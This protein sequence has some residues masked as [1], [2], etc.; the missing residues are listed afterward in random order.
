MEEQIR[1]LMDLTF[2]DTGTAVVEI[3]NCP[4]QAESVPANLDRFDELD[5]EVFSKQRW[6]LLVRSHTE[7][8]RVIWPDGHE[9]RGI[10]KH[11]EDLKAMFVALPD[12]RIDQHPVK[13][14]SG[15][16][17][18]VIGVMEGTFSKP[19][20]IP[21]GGVI[22][23]N[24]NRVS[25]RMATIAHWRNGRIYEEYLFWDNDAYMKQLGLSK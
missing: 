12:L 2:P 7:D 11:I 3:E 24:G 14:G 1:G 13:F 4:E 20:W 17:T 25:L 21:K 19:M 16:W 5:F 15:E 9:T 22:E 6:D 10:G 18:A 23:P 8:V